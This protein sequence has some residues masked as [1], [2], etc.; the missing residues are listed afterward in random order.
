M[1]LPAAAAVVDHDQWKPPTGSRSESFSNRVS[2]YMNGNIL[3][4]SEKHVKIVTT[5]V[6]LAAQIFGGPL[7]KIASLI[8]TGYAMHHVY[9]NYS[10]ITRYGALRAIAA[11]FSV[12]YLGLKLS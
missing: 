1:A 3:R 11:S 2:V 10:A 7:V 5:V 6:F 9:E 12:G 4:G 8:F